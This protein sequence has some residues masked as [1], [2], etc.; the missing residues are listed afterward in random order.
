[1]REYYVYIK[2]F[3]NFIIVNLISTHFQQLGTKDRNYK[4]SIADKNLNLIRI[5]TT[6]NNF[7]SSS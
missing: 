2:F 4:V 3:T 6:Y 1:M 5:S 7:T